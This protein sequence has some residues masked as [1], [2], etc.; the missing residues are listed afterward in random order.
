MKT[1]FFCMTVI[2]FALA[3]NSATAQLDIIFSISDI[4]SNAGSELDLVLGS[5]GSMYV[6]VTNNDLDVLDGVG[7]DLLSSDTSILEATSHDIG[8]PS[9]RWSAVDGGDLGDLATD[10]IAF[11]LVGLGA[12]G[13]T[14]DGSTVLFSEV[15][16]DATALGETELSIVENANAISILGSDA[17]SINFG[18]ARVSVSAVPEPSS[19][20][21]LALVGGMVGLRRRRS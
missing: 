1:N 5:S 15:R 16:F 20:M 19:F 21:V 2:M 9:S 17:Q 10:T 6:W 13:I 8:N 18:T 3:C 12:N 4:D 7:I 11:A 14:N